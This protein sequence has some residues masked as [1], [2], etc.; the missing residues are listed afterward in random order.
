M[1][2]LYLALFFLP[3]ETMMSQNTYVYEMSMNSYNIGYYYVEYSNQVS[4]KDTLVAQFYDGEQ[5]CANLPVDF[6]IG[7]DTVSVIT[8]KTGCV[9]LDFK[10]IGPD[11]ILTVFI[12]PTFQKID[13]MKANVYFWEWSGQQ[14]PTKLNVFVEN[15]YNPIVHIKSKK[16]LS[17]SDME[18]IKNTILNDSVL[19]FNTKD[20]DVSVIMHL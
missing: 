5:P 3:I 18:R 20:I 9:Y 2:K 15:Q 6:V 4:P 17:P 13:C 14:H 19:W 12:H 16:Q 8:D 10:I 7:R 1:R 11:D